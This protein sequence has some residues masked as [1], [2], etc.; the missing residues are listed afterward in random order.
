[1]NRGELLPAPPVYRF[2]NLEKMMKPGLLVLC[3]LFAATAFAQSS[4]G[5]ANLS[6]ELQFSTHNER[7][8]QLPMAQEQNL[9]SNSSYSFAQGERPLCDVARRMKKEHETAKKAD[10]IWSN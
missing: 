10:I 2:Y 3:L 6:N 5:S 9:L 1:M 4:S 8:T 7:A